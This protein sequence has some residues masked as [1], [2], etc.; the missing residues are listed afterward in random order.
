[1]FVKKKAGNI[2]EIFSNGLL[3]KEILVRIKS[4]NGFFLPNPTL[5][6]VASRFNQKPTQDRT[7]NKVQGR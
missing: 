7:T 6:E 3:G 4:G 5:S 1:M 2:V